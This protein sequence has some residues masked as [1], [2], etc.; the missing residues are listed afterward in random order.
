MQIVRYSRQGPGEGLGVNKASGL[1][2]HGQTRRRRQ[3]T[4]DNDRR[5]R[6]RSDG[7]EARQAMD[8]TKQKQKQKQK[9]TQNGWCCWSAG[10]SSAE[11]GDPGR[12]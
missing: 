6:G 5:Q 11:G 2:T 10:P 7:R 1:P 4:E 8:E 3:K 9:Q 12:V